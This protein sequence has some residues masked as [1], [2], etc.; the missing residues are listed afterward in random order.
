[1]SD[2]TFFLLSRVQTQSMRASPYIGPFED[3]VKL[4]EAKLS[5]TQD[6]IDQ[7]LKCQGG[8]LYL[9]PIFGSPDIMQQMPNEGRKFKSVDT[10]WRRTMEK[11]KK[12]AT[13]Q[14]TILDGPSI[15]A[16]LS[17]IRLKWKTLPK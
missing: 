2:N 11:L 5:L 7:W 9:E 1:M 14:L 15:R 3:R 10:T 13:A 8:W 17:I 16:S 4:F 6:I 12:V